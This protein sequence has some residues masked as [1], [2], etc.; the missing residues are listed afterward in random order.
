MFLSKSLFFSLIFLGRAWNFGKVVILSI[1]GHFFDFFQRHTIHSL[2]SRL[3]FLTM[4]LLVLY[5]HGGE[6]P[7]NRDSCNQSLTAFQRDVLDMAEK[8]SQRVPIS[9][10]V[11][12]EHE[13]MPPERNQAED[14]VL[15]VASGAGIYHAMMNF[16]EVTHY[17][18]F[19]ILVG[20]FATA[21]E[22]LKEFRF[23]LHSLPDARVELLDLGFTGGL[24]LEE[25]KATWDSQYIE[26]LEAR[27]DLQGYLRKPLVYEVKFKGP[28]SGW[29]KKYFY[30]HFGDRSKDR[31]LESVTESLAP[32]QQL[33]AIFQ[34]GLL[35]TP[36]AKALHHFL[37]HG[38]GQGV[39]YLD[40]SSKQSMDPEALVAQF[41]TILGEDYKVI[42]HPEVFEKENAYPYSRWVELRRADDL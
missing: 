39:V 33:I 12:R 41:Q 18:F 1:E 40:Y 14:H 4:T 32:D 6:P 16:P 26:E 25:L 29:Q 3:L 19:D 11:G 21:E 31:H 2:M 23:R 24:T 5:A 22:F 38:N 28:Q 20:W 15:Y 13:W 27:K 8:R 10:F 17:H 36:S 37:E 9:T 30:L 42:A 35:G 34:T 7:V